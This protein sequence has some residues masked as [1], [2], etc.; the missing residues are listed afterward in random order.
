MTNTA[1]EIRQDN[2]QE[3]DSEDSVA[4]ITVSCDG[5]LA[6]SLN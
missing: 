4:N 1:E 5:T 2:I 3:G 6:I